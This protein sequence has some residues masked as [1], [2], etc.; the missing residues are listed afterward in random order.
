MSN[1]NLPD[2][3]QL[4]I[5]KYLQ[6]KNCKYCNNQLQKINNNFCNYKCIRNY[7]LSMQHKINYLHT[8]LGLLIGIWVPVII[9]PIEII[10][11]LWLLSLV[12]Y[13]FLMFYIEIYFIRI[14]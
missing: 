14:Y 3:L 1:I 9:Y 6:N 5:L 13:I 2:E 11:F 12:T 7:N 4:E 8:G 10:K